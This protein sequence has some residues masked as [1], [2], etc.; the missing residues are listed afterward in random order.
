MGNSCYVAYFSFQILLLSYLDALTYPLN[1]TK[2]ADAV[3][4]DIIDAFVRDSI[5]DQS[6]FEWESQLR[7][8][9]MREPDSLVVQQCTGE[10]RLS[11]VML[12]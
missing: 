1:F 2:L 12:L 11:L 4:R 6:E 7:F 5:L 8:Y 3:C 9:W 10:S